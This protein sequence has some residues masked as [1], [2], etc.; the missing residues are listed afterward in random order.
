[1]STVF[2]VQI[3]IFFSCTCWYDC[4]L[5]LVTDYYLAKLMLCTHSNY[6][7]I[8]SITVSHGM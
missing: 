6:Y 2:I 1:M 7:V 3:K 8:V 4:Y 5:K